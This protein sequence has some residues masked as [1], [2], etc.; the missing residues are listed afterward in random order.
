MS[1]YQRIFIIGHPGAGKALFAKKLAE[2]LDWQFVDAD[3]GLEFRVGR[4][5]VDMIGK[6]GVAAWN[7]CQSKIL[8]ALIKQKHIVVTTDA[9]IVGNE[10][11][12]A[13]LSSE[14][15]VYLKV[16]TAVQI[17]RTARNPKPLL[18]VDRLEIFLN[19]LHQERDKLYEK[20]TPVVINSH[21]DTLAEQVSRIVKM[22][23]AGQETPRVNSQLK[24]DKEDCLFFHKQLHTPI[25]LSEQ[26]ATCLKLLAL[27]KTSKD[28][29]LEMHLSYRTVEDYLAQTMELLGCAS[30][31]E[32]IALYY[33]QP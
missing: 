7:D 31:K 12:R 13:L 23:L 19:K 33:D 16:G 29:A 6:Q 32:L 11:N 14:L 3:L 8:A 15:V 27:G 1:L 24:L 9:S 2:K 10:K 4:T 28:I 30:S 21:N 17:E 5:L 20:V 26:Q 22:V 25:L 18:T